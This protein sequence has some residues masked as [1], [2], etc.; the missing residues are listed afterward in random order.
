[1]LF[2]PLY[3]PIPIIVKVGFSH[4]LVNV[5]DRAADLTKAI[6]WG[7]FLP[8][9]I[10]AVPFAYRLEKWFHRACKPVQVSVFKGS[11]STETYPAPL[12]IPVLLFM[13]L[14]W[15]G[16]FWAVGEVCGFDGISWYWSFLAGIWGTIAD[17]AGCIGIAV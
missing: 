9:C 4:D 6:K 2:C 17:V 14:V 16:Y 8:I 11:G 1:M 15:A 5:F 10:V 7:C 13:S 12:G 3:V